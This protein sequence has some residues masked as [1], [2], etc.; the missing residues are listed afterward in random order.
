[1]RATSLF[2][3]STYAAW[4]QKEEEESSHYAEAP[5]AVR[6]APSLPTTV[7]GVVDNWLARR[8]RTPL[9]V[10]VGTSKRWPHPARDTRLVLPTRQLRKQRHWQDSNVITCLT[11]N[12][13]YRKSGEAWLRRT[14]GGASRPELVFAQ[15]V[16]PALVTSPPQGY[17]SPSPL[18]PRL[19]Q[20]RVEP[21]RCWSAMTFASGIK[22]A[23]LSGQPPFRHWEHMLP[24]RELVHRLRLYGL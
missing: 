4:L 14:L 12:L 21:R 9:S 11:R 3:W 2:V 17:R 13:A 16:L 10:R 6:H 7:I 23:Q 18:S 24:W 1:M 15:E 19:C 8:H 20:R 5:T 22:R